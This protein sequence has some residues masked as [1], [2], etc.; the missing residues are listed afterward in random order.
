MDHCFGRKN[1][2]LLFSLSNLTLLCKLCHFKKTYTIR[3]YEKLVDDR[4][5]HREGLAWWASAFNEIQKSKKWDRETL[6]NK[7]EELADSLCRVGRFQSEL[8]KENK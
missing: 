1:A 5:K 2:I 3:G 7:I 6:E 8:D 4:V